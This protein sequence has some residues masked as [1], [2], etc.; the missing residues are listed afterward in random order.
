MLGSGRSQVYR[1]IESSPN[2]AL[3]AVDDYASAL[4]HRKA[5]T[6]GQNSIVGFTD[7][8]PVRCPMCCCL[9]YL[10]TYSR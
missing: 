10:K 2:T 1:T 9:P 6:C 7:S 8:G 4:T 5:I 3:S